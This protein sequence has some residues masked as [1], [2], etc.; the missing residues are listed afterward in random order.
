MNSPS[1]SDRRKT[2]SFHRCWIVYGGIVK[3]KTVDWAC[4]AV[5][6][7]IE[8]PAGG[9]GID[10]PC[11]WGYGP[12][13]LTVQAYCLSELADI[14]VFITVQPCM[15]LS[16]HTII[17]GGLTLRSKHNINIINFVLAYIQQ[18]PQ[19]G[20]EH[21]SQL[22]KSLFFLIPRLPSSSI[23][24]IQCYFLLFC[25]LSWCWSQ[26]WSQETGAS[27][28]L[29]RVTKLSSVIVFCVCIYTHVSMIK[30]LCA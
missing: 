17:A 28:M 9:W 2:K 24:I 22:S 20:C 11:R 6:C 5:G 18:H 19:Q 8:P 25:S 1:T 4:N 10:A 23:M 16:V 30:C 7:W 27:R 3:R 14:T 12:G 13:R 21:L 29:V 26:S 15:A